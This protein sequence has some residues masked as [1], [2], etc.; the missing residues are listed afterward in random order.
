[1]CHGKVFEQSSGFRCFPFTSK[2]FSQVIRKFHRYWKEGMGYNETQIP[3]N[4]EETEEGYLIIVPLPGRSKEDINVSLIGN[5]LN[6]KAAKP[7][8]VK[9]EKRT[10]NK[11]KG[12]LDS[13]LRNSFTF[14]DVDMDIVLPADADLDS[15]KSAIVNGVLKIK[16]GKK[17]SKHID[18]NSEGNN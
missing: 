11:S 13:F 3:Y 6:I 7:K 15:I 14:I 4:L 1:M 2:D 17:P 12:R 18:I 10:E 5:S 16:L 9:E 8:E